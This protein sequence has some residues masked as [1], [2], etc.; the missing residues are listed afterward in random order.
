[1]RLRTVHNSASFSFGEKALEKTGKR[2][3]EIERHK[4]KKF[5]F[6][7]AWKSSNFPSMISEILNS[8]EI[9]WGWNQQSAKSW[10][11]LLILVRIF[12]HF[13]LFEL[14]LAEIM[15]ISNYS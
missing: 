1:M 2:N 9:I 8:S 13:L 6:F 14:K 11:I 5:E 4:I 12:H 15:K 3:Q 7:P 10:R